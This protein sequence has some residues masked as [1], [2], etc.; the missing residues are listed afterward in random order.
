MRFG[1]KTSPQDTTWSGMLAVWQAADEIDLFES[2]WTFD[3]FYPI[4]T[5]DISGPCMEGW[6]VTSA[7]AQATSRIRIGVLVTGIHYRHPAVLAKLAVSADQSGAV[8][9]YDTTT[10][11]VAATLPG[12]PGAAPAQNEFRSAG[13]PAYGPDGRLYVGSSGGHLRVFDPTTFAQVADIAVPDRSTVED[14]LSADFF[15]PFANPRHAHEFRCFEKFA[16][17][18]DQDI[19]GIGVERLDDHNGVIAKYNGQATVNFT[20]K[21]Y[22]QMYITE[23]HF[24]HRKATS[25]AEYFDTAVFN[26]AFTP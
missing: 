18:D 19:V 17:A 12:V 23:V 15:L 4:F 1:I 21:P 14:F 10:G 24:R 3:H 25:W 16:L 5:D 8:T 9:V 20:G 26:E 6:T 22:N 11:T 13:P 2:A 7:L